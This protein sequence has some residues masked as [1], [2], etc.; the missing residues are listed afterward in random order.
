[1]ILHGGR[2]AW[3]AAGLPMEGSP[4]TPPDEDCID[5]LF[6]F[7]AAIWVAMKPRS[8]ILSGKKICLPR[9]RRTAMP[10]SQ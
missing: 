9:L 3:E 1:M 4:D 7:R 10:D 5:Y 2:E 6:W 8:L